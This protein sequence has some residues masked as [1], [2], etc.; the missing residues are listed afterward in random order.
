[1][2]P[3]EVH[4]CAS[5]MLRQPTSPL[6]LVLPEGFQAVP[7]GPS[8]Q[9]PINDPG[10]SLSSVSLPRL[11]EPANQIGQSQVFLQ[12]QRPTS[13][14]GDD[15]TVDRWKT[16][17]TVFKRVFPPPVI[18]ALLG[19]FVALCGPIRGIL[20][21]INDRDGDAPLQSVFTGMS[22]L[23][24]AAVPINMMILGNSLAKGFNRNTVTMRMV[25][26][27]SAI[28]VAR[29]LVMPLFGLGVTLLMQRANVM[30]P[31]ADAAFY[32]VSMLVSS[33]PTANN[34][35]VMAELGGANKEDLGFCILVQYMI[36][37]LVLTFW[38]FLFVSVATRTL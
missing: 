36:S 8:G 26:T 34:I 17:G 15:A 13:I 23:G 19:M 3:R 7:V 2:Q 25:K 14:D 12:D 18:A 29:M 30:S 9:R 21:D 22:K 33:T 28:A 24:G 27:A 20:V 11:G 4:S 1:M 35:M 37:P 32:L 5:P 31:P 10:S 16:W 38:L 6:H